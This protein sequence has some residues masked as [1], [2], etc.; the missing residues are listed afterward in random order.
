MK[1]STDS[2]TFLMLARC[3]ARVSQVKSR[4]LWHLTHQSKLLERAALSAPTTYYL[5]KYHQLHQL[6]RTCRI[7]ERVPASASAYSLPSHTLVVKPSSGAA[8]W[9][10]RLLLKH[11]NETPV[12]EGLLG[13]AHNHTS[14]RRLRCTPVVAVTAAAAVAVLLLGSAFSVVSLQQRPVEVRNIQLALARRRRRRR[15]ITLL[16]HKHTTLVRRWRDP[17]ELEAT[18]TIGGRGPA[19]D[20]DATL[21]HIAY[22]YRPHTHCTPRLCQERSSSLLHERA[23]RHTRRSLSTSECRVLACSPACLTSSSHYDGAGLTIALPGTTADE[24]HGAFPVPSDSAQR[25]RRLHLAHRV[26]VLRV[27]QGC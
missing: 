20:Y 10:S 15:A 14:A 26:R 5:Q 22:T 1:H 24:H 25:P 7:A 18:S 2:L 8:Y 11:F 12:E 23:S 27:V 19:T 9:P 16:T 3:R 4:C 17:R 6:Q 21:T 13:R